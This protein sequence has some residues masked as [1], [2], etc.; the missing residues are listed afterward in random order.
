MPFLPCHPRPLWPILLAGFALICTSC[1]GNDSPHQA[2]RPSG[3]APPI[4]E[5]PSILKNDRVTNESNATPY[6]LQFR[7]IPVPWQPWDAQ[8]FAAAEKTAR[9]VFLL[10]GRATCATSYHFRKKVLSDK[11]VQ[12]LLK[13]NYVCVLIDADAQPG[14]ITTIREQLPQFGIRLSEPIAVFITSHGLPF[15]PVNFSE[16][17]ALTPT[18]L[19]L[20]LESLTSRWKDQQSILIESSERLRELFEEFTLPLAPAS[21]PGS[22]DT[23]ANSILSE[24]EVTYN[25]SSGTFASESLVYPRPTTIRMFLALA[26]KLPEDDPRAERALSMATHSLESLARGAIRD[27]LDG[28]FFHSSV[29]LGWD[30]PSSE[31]PTALQALLLRAYLDAAQRTENPEFEDIARKLTHFLIEH[32]R[33]ENGLFISARGAFD[34]NPQ[35]RLARHYLWST[36]EIEQALPTDQWETFRHFYRIVPSGNLPPTL[37]AGRDTHRLNFLK[38]HRTT[39]ETATERGL[40]E[41][42]IRQH[43]TSAH[44]T[45]L[46]L[47]SQRQEETVNHLIS[48]SVNGLAVSA[49]VHAAAVLDDPALLKTATE[50]VRHLEEIRAA[51]TR[52]PGSYHENPAAN[53]A[54]SHYDYALWIQALLDVA[55]ATGDNTWNTHAVQLYDESQNLFWI[56]TEQLFKAFIGTT[57][58]HGL[59]WY[60]FSDTNLPSHLAVTAANM[61]RMA[62]LPDLGSFRPIAHDILLRADSA[63]RPRNAHSL[64]FH[65][66]HWNPTP[67]DS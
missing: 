4:A 24:V 19:K 53:F 14:V 29:G 5:I 18:H 61:K 56:E 25:Q 33:H 32:C 2:K 67:G 17:Q 65:R 23:L 37:S 15:Q 52:L 8:T 13:D 43:L 44:Q 60:I 26:S 11:T 1:G 36:V 63:D 41:G 50:T 9:P 38:P 10:S 51:M 30:L 27:P 22:L 3:T 57:P 64:L 35:I 47:R 48:L 7:D 16:E 59:P 54:P 20:T 42:T 31:K 45:L 40:P 6:H 49:L 66:L 62:N 58:D 39:A 21:S 28:G 34:P 55:D 12:T 46:D